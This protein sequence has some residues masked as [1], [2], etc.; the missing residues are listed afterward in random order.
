MS[1]DESPDLVP[2]PAAAVSPEHARWRAVAA[3]VADT[4]ATD[5]L[6]RDRANQPPFA[7]VD[8]LRRSG[9]LG[10]RIPTA[11]GGAGQ[12]LTTTFDVLRTIGRVDG[13]IAHLLGYHYN[14][15][16]GS[17]SDAEP[18]VRGRIWA[19]TLAE[20]WFWASTGSPQDQDLV[21]EPAGHGWTISGRKHFATGSRVADRLFGYVLD[22]DTRHRL[23]VTLNPSKPELVRRDD[24]DMLGQR[25]SASNGLDF[26]A[27]PVDAADLLI[28]YGPADG[29]PQ[30]ARSLGVLFSQLLFSQLCQAIADGALL[31]ARDYT[32]TSSRPWFHAAV[33]SASDDP[34]IVQTY[35]LLASRLSAV[36][37]LNAQA[38]ATLEWA[39]G[40]GDALTVLERARVSEVIATSRVVANEVAL[41]VAN[42]VYDLT[43]ARAT[44]SRYGFDLAWRNIRTLT[45]HDP[46]AYKATEVGAYF[47][48]GTLPT[49][50]PYR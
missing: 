36:A 34:F 8:L 30:P 32:R 6:A 42:R 10:L 24:W 37:A 47:L 38:T 40:R 18:E 48:S 14:F 1:V 12:D 41:E 19:Q 21:L 25:L 3:E 20:Q 29:P 27:Y 31:K 7:E 49:P 15:L 26:H 28:D 22:P 46:Q 11:H 33:S 23:V 13:S 44:D 9:L 16:V 4:L 35:G 43:G 2:Q 5:A 45:L 39:H 17:L 50:S